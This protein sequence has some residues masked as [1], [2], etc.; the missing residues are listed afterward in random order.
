MRALYTW[1]FVRSL[2]RARISDLHFR[3]YGQKMSVTAG[4]IPQM[5]NPE[6]PLAIYNYW[7][8]GLSIESSLTPI[9]AFLNACPNSTV[10]QMFNPIS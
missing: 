1:H 6:H 4:R 5:G 2:H 3:Q 10:Y 9:F 7:D 8:V